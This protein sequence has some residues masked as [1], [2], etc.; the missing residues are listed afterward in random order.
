[1]PEKPLV[2]TFD[3]QTVDHLG[4]RMYSQLPNAVAELVANAFDAD[5]HQVVVRIGKDGTISVEDDG[6]GMSRDDLADKYL[7]IGRNRRRA[8]ASA[9]T[10]SG[11]RH[12]SGKKGLGKLALFGIGKR[13]VLE[14]TRG[15][16]STGMQV[17]LS[18]DAMMAAEGSYRPDERSLPSLPEAHGTTV[19]LTELKRK[20]PIDPTG[21]ASSLARLFDYV[22][23]DFAITVVPPDGDP[24]A[25]D[26]L[27]RLDSVEEEFSWVL[28]EDLTDQDVFL[29]TNGVRGRIVSTRKPLRNTLR[30]ITLYAS[31]R[32]VNEP[33]F[34]GS[35]ESSY[36]Y[37]YLTGALDIDFIDNDDNDVI[38]TDRR[39]V[40][41]ET[42]VTS[43]L[44]SALQHLLTRIGQEWRELRSAAR[45]VDR[46]KRIGVATDEWISSIKSESEQ[47]SVRNIVNRIDELDLTVAQ[48]GALLQDI[49]RLAPP[50]AEY[51]WRHLHS[52]IQD[53]TK[54]TYNRADY[55]QAVQEAIKRYVN[56]AKTKSGVTAEEATAIVTAA[57]GAD[58]GRLSVFAK[59]G[60]LQRFTQLSAQN[61]EN[62]QKHLSMGIVAGF[63]NPLAHEE[64][65]ALH[66]SGA[67]TY[68]DCLDALSIISHLT[69]RL[70][71][72]ER[73]DPSSSKLNI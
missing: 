28:P 54:D 17:E 31:G 30:G 1:V 16:S 7:R 27:L 63:R 13:V 21:L 29:H 59:Y 73:R 38:A 47:E 71:D 51:V 25:V 64:I 9:M 72:A 18:Y 66:E 14:T 5:A 23:A 3:P 70:G 19:T 26:P 36:A 46:E 50:N 8:E 35:S 15:G 20:T 10:E 12:V 58:N 22:D 48:E 56:L 44:R 24:I 52:E 55:F 39:A 62:G 34:F 45:K 11:L 61:V 33:E 2:L 43:E 57:F 42:G 6:H 49:N 69:R 67:F 53:A 60:V 40:D 68:Q 41:W 4:A 65:K 37:S 32:M